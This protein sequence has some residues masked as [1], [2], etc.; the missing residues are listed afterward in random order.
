MCVGGKGVR[1]LFLH[2]FTYVYERTHKKAADSVIAAVA[3][4]E[5]VG[6]IG[7]R[8]SVG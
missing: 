7:D 8:S 6:K 1:Y 2:I 3:Q 4:I 5:R